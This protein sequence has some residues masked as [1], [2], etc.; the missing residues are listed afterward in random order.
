MRSSKVLKGTGLTH[1]V[2]PSSSQTR[3]AMHKELTSIR[4]ESIIVS[5]TLVK[6][7]HNPLCG[8]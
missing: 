7:V 3:S 8:L 6:D 5:S 1:P 4:D 2:P